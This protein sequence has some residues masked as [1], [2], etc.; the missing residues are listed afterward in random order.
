[1]KQVIRQCQL[2]V[3]KAMTNIQLITMKTNAVDKI[4]VEQL[5]LKEWQ[6]KTKRVR[7]NE[8]FNK[9]ENGFYRNLNTTS[10]TGEP[11]NMDTFEKYWRGIWEDVK[12]VRKQPWMDGIENELRN[13][14]AILN[15][16]EVT[17]ED[18]TIDRLDWKLY[19]NT[20]RGL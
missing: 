5:R 6:R 7:N 8:M 11:P 12:D 17:V 4:K 20:C 19:E 3:D 13:K 9:S 15:E 14:V 16:M 2:E 1:M 10:H 18:K